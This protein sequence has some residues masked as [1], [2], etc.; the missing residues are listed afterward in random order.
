MIQGAVSV[1]VDEFLA[2][3]FEAKG[4]VHTQALDHV[5]TV[6]ITHM[7]IEMQISAQ[8][9]RFPFL[10]VAPEMPRM[11]ISSTGPINK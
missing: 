6:K 3:A 5:K 9:S 4:T 1:D 7:Y 10:P 2:S 11:G 8:R